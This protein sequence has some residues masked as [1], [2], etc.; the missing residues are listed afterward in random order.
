MA[1][2][3]V[4]GAA[5]LHKAVNPSASPAAVRSALIASGSTA[6]WSGDRDSTKEPLID[7]SQLGGGSTPPPPPPPPTPEPTIDA[8]AVSVTAP[9]SVNRG[10]AAT[11]SVA[12]KNN[13]SATATIPVK[14]AETPGG[15]T[16][17]K[18]ISLA[19]GAT[20]TVSFSWATTS[21]T[22]TGAH[23]LTATTSLAS[24]NNAGNNTA[25]TTINVAA[26][27]AQTMSVSNLTLTAS[28]YSY[29]YRLSSQAQIKSNGVAIGGARVTVEFQYPNGARYTMA[30]N[31]NTAG[32]A[33]FTR[34]VSAKGAYT[35]TV[36]SVTK[37]GMTY[38]AA[39]NLVSSK[40]VT[41]Q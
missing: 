8:Q 32:T 40:S 22:A 35:V 25:S 19:A 16:Q 24:D 13:G 11:V 7:A 9:A 2:P 18:S 17:T 31:T 1:S 23:A 5:A 28:R 21:G 26:P 39:G 33:A 41:I 3:H 38:D 10:S 37:S 4:A 29:Y 20:G 15:F 14:L 6:T 27:V 12:V 30:A 36:K 34:T